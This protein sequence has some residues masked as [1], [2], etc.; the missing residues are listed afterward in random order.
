MKRRRWVLAALLVV[1]VVVVFLYYV[2]V[3]AFVQ[4]RTAQAV[5]DRF[6]T[7]NESFQG[8]EFCKTCHAQHYEQW[9][10]SLHSKAYTEAHFAERAE[11]L[12]WGM[13]KESCLYCHSPLAKQGVAKEEAITCEVCHGPG[14]TRA[15]VR[16]VCVRCH[17]QPMWGGTD[18]STTILSTPFEFAD[19]SAKREGI[20]CVD[21][22]M[23]KQGGISFH[24]FQGSRVA[25][26][27]YKGVVRV[28]GIERRG[29][30]VVV[31][32][33]NTVTGHWLPTGAETN[34]IFLEVVAFDAQG[35]TVH[36]SEYRFEK[37]V[38]FFRTIPM[39]VTGDT[40]L[41]DGEQRQVAFDVPAS[42]TRVS[43]TLKIKLRLWNNKFDEFVIDQKDV[44]AVPTR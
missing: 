25:P 9:S 37:S 36:Q 43:A 7:G 30:Q 13:S 29:G 24:G 17:G 19:S 35:Q 33:R 8:A 39:W 2:A 21:C 12:G 34:V 28:E 5:F 23:P 42:T 31:T 26:E 11:E 22:H 41:R 44:A 27:T 40:R 1:V 38:F 4:S 15:V 6:V 18:P 14:M 10:Q 3:P 32:V 16:D 20:T